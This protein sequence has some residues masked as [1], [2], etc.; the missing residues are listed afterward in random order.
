MGSD[1]CYN[2]QACSYKMNYPES[3]EIFEEVKKVKKIL[4][5]CHRGPDPDGIGSTLAMRLVLVNMGKE[6]EIICPSGPISKQASYLTGYD[7]I[8]LGVDFGKFDFSKFDLFIT[9]DTPNVSLLTGKD[10]GKMPDIKTVIVDHHHLSTL[11]GD[12]RLIDETATSVGEML[13]DVFEDWGIKFNRDIAECL[14]TSIIGDTGAFAY[15]NVTPKTL[16]I[17]S[18][19]MA[20][21]PDKNMIADRIYRSEDFEMIKFWSAI[22]SK[23]EIDRDHKFVY[24]FMSYDEYKKFSR[25]DDAKAKAASLFAPIV[26]GTN[27]GFIGIEEKPKYMTVSFRGRTDFDTSVIAKEL[28]GGGHKVASATKIEGLSFEDASNKVLETARKYAK[29]NSR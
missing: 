11:S 16:S 29:K 13:Y 1:G 6:V 20:L 3:A 27:F 15:P 8:R 21:G 19:L 23:M 25:L 17:A 22:L 26:E 2:I 24:S 4:L 7:W 5:N 18:K 28:G 9:L 12:I 10:A 14:L